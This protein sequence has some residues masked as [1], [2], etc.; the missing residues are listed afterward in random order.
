MDQTQVLQ[1]R[2]VFFLLLFECAE[3]VP[4]VKIALYDPSYTVYKIDILELI[5]LGQIDM[6]IFITKPHINDLR[7]YLLWS[8]QDLGEY[9]HNDD[10]WN[11]DRS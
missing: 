6:Y 8:C 7:V 2:N 11:V 4:E 9:V 1:L 5:C 3:S 10:N